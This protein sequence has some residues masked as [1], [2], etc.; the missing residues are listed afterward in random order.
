MAVQS[1]TQRET[2]STLLQCQHLAC[3][4]RGLGTL[5]AF[6]GLAECP[7]SA[8]RQEGSSAG[9]PT[10]AQGFSAVTHRLGWV[11]PTTKPRPKPL[12]LK[13]TLM[14]QRRPCI[15]QPASH[16]LM[17]GPK[18]LGDYWVHLSLVQMGKLKPKDQI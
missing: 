14:A 11:A 12:L 7:P 15:T 18:T 3:L 17:S 1:Q 9:L 10:R 13:G 6:R 4:S 5:K 16:Y 2:Q 8:P